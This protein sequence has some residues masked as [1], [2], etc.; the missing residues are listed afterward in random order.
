MLYL[1]RKIIIIIIII[2]IRALC[3]FAPFLGPTLHNYPGAKYAGQLCTKI[4]KV[5]L[6]IILQLQLSRLFQC[7]TYG[8][9]GNGPSTGGGFS[10]LYSS[11]LFEAESML[12][13]HRARGVTVF[14]KSWIVFY[15][16]VLLRDDLMAAYYVR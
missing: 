5:Q 15:R 8:P 7:Q 12:Y 13:E 6:T 16:L 9:A 14:C 1:L 2:I 11:Y 3:L 4:E 10:P